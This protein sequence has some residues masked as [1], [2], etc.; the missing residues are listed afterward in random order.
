ML[1]GF[2]LGSEYWAYEGE[3]PLNELPTVQSMRYRLGA[4]SEWNQR[5]AEHRAWRPFL[6]GQFASI[7]IMSLPVAL[8]N[9]FVDAGWERTQMGWKSSFLIFVGV[10]VF[11]ACLVGLFF[12][13]FKLLAAALVLAGFG[14]AMPMRNSAFNHDFESLFYIGIPLVFFTLALLCVHRLARAREAMMGLAAMAWLVFVLSSFQMSRVGHDAAAALEES[15]VR[16]F[17]VIRSLTR[18]R[19]VSVPAYLRRNLVRLGQAPYAVDFYLAN[20]WRQGPDLADF[21][22][23]SREWAESRPL[24]TPENRVV[25]LVE[26]FSYW[27]IVA[28]VDPPAIANYFDVQ[29]DVR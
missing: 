1:L 19:S 24:L 2:N 15:L 10:S 25:F 21:V 28:E 6:K 27:D 13:R 18:D 12:V 14:W 20:S 16:D 5:V 8:P 3:I 29:M 7:G 17:E 22:L 11:G 4:D 23:L 9:H 26:P